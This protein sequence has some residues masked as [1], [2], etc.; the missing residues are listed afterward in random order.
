VYVESETVG[1]VIVKRDGESALNVIN[2]VKE[3]LKEVK[4]ALPEGVELVTTYDRSDLILRAIATLR[5]KLSEE[6]IVVSLVIIV[7]LF[8]VRSSL[9]P[10]FTLPIAVLLSFIPMYY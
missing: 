5:E 4:R 7:F 1:K 9:I 2:A 6:M 10:I 8:H 3:K